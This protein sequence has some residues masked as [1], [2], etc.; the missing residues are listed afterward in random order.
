[1]GK[2]LLHDSW[3]SSFTLRGIGKRTHQRTTLERGWWYLVG[4]KPSGGWPHDSESYEKYVKCGLG[5]THDWERHNS[6]GQEYRD[7]C[8]RVEL[9]VL[10]ASGVRMHMCL[11]YICCIW[12]RR[13]SPQVL[14]TRLTRWSDIPGRE[15]RNGMPC[16]QTPQSSA[17]SHGN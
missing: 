15:D 8:L 7:L 13:W 9:F 3:V 11:T 17:I 1:M 2:N 10:Q 4:S 5:L 16:F 6:L 12:Q 14:L